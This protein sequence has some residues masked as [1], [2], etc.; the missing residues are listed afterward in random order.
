M[1][2][3]R[4]VGLSGS[5]PWSVD[6]PNGN[7]I[8]F[9]LR[10]TGSNM[11]CACFFKGSEDDLSLSP[12]NVVDDGSYY[13]IL[14]VYDKGSAKVNAWYGDVDNKESVDVDADNVFTMNKIVV[15]G[16]GNNGHRGSIAHHA[17]WH[18]ALTDSDAQRLF[19]GEN[20]LG[21][22]GQPVVYQPLLDGLRD[23]RSFFVESDWAPGQTP[24]V[25][26]GD[27]PSVNAPP[28]WRILTKGTS[29]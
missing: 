13:P 8:W 26:S 14:F 10:Y 11:D 12:G 17:I 9:Q 27:N 16:R 6:G 1:Q 25:L 19:N 23:W 5:I 3:S 7:N 28:G 21:I 22:G 20:P 15:G 29:S 24:P 2:V 18:R 4:D